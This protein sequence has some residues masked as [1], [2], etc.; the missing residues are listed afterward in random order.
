MSGGTWVSIIALLGWLILAL[1]AY[2]SR[3]INGRK[4]LTMALTWGA[5][6]LAVAFFFTL[7]GK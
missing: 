4:T 6:F 2:R 1:G 7:V 5:I 3:R